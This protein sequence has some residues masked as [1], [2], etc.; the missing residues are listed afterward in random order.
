MMYSCLL[1]RRPRMEVRSV[2]AR[3]RDVLPWPYVNSTRAHHA[4]YAARDRHRSDRVEKAFAAIA[5]GRFWHFTFEAETLN[6]RPVLRYSGQWS[7]RR[8]GEKRCS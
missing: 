8:L 3:N 1:L 6:L 2:P 4:R 5:H 7:E